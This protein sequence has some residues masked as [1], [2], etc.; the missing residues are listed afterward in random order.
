MSDHAYIYIVPFKSF[1]YFFND[2]FIQQECIQLIK[3]D[4]ILYVYKV[5]KKKI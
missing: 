5:T 1:F 2:T 4:S 3:R